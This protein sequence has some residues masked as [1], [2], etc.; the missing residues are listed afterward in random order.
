MVDGAVA[1]L[2]CWRRGRS[3]V[4]GAFGDVRRRVDLGDAGLH[5]RHRREVASP[6]FDGMPHHAEDGP[7]T[8]ASAL[9]YEPDVTANDGHALHGEGLVRQVVDDLLRRARIDRRTQ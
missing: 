7:A 8:A 9:F 3:P 2:T 6:A 5:G 4:V 1:A